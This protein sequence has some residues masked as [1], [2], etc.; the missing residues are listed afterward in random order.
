M[1]TMRDAFNLPV[2][3]SDHTSGIQV[4]LAARALGASVVEK[5]FTL[6]RSLPGPDHEASVEP[7][8]LGALVAGIRI[9][10]S[11]LGNGRKEPAPSEAGTAAVARKSLVASQSIPAG[12]MLTEDMIAVKRPGT[13]LLPSLRG[14]L[15]G[16]RTVQD[17]A[18]GAL[19]SLDMVS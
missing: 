13:G 12:T 6:D 8:E 15:V 9:V 5:H 18:E 1:R 11:A 10:E 14:E 3:Y 4:A 17:I 2:G 16:R 7:A 19:F